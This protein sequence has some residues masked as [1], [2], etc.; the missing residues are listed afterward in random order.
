MS[1]RSPGM[2]KRQG[3]HITR[4]HTSL[5]MSH[6]CSFKGEYRVKLKIPF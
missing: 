5:L 1:G 6:P 4:D 2:M 3:F